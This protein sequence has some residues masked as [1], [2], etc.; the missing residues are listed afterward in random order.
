[1]DE[2]F[3]L[4]LHIDGRTVHTN[5]GMHSV[6]YDNGVSVWRELAPVLSITGQ[7]IDKTL[8]KLIILLLHKMS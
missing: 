3:G 7:A 6:W 8:L 2:S 5:I 1:M 4:V